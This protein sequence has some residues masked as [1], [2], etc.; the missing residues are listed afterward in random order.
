ME[1]IDDKKDSNL[2]TAPT[3]GQVLMRT[4]RGIYYLVDL[5]QLEVVTVPAANIEARAH[6]PL[7]TVVV[8]RGRRMLAIVRVHRLAIG[9]RVELDVATTDGP[10]RA[11]TMRSATAVVSIEPVTIR[12]EA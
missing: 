2:G 6:N 4:R 12:R 10:E 3:Q 8:R 1:D 11:Y 9:S 5:D 7:R